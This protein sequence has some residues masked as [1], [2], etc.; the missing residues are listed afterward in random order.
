MSLTSENSLN[1]VF[2]L[3]GPSGSGKTSLAKAIPLPEVI[4]YK[5]RDIREGEQEGVHGYFISEQEFLEMDKQ[6]LWIAKTF[7]CGNYYGVTQGEL[8][9]LEDSPMIYVIDWDGVL[10]FK[11]G[12]EKIQ[13]YS[14]DQIVTIFIHAPREDLAVRLAQRNESKDTIKARLDRADRDYAISHRCD[15]VVTNANGEFHKALSEILK[16]I[17]KESFG[18]E[19]K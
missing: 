3:V 19:K 5:T 6:D 13:G 1:K 7:Y 10:I 9:P 8:L 18:L 11:E 16:I 15:Y 4:S 14:K 17:I 2:C 12:I